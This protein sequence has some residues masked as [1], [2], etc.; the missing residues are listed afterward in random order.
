MASYKNTGVWD[1]KDRREVI[2]PMAKPG[3]AE[4]KQEIAAM[5]RVDSERLGRAEQTMKRIF[6][7]R[8]IAQGKQ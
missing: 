7:Y 8:Q 6:A 1:I 4:Y 3:S 5:P 2:L